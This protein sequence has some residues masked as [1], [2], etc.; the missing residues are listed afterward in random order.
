MNKLDA[1]VAIPIETEAVPVRRILGLNP[2]PMTGPGTN[3]Y[4]IG[5]G[6]PVTSGSWASR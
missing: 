5:Q 3:S 2:G 6:A 4:L 1:G